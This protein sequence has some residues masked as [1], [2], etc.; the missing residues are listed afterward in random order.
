MEAMVVTEKTQRT[1]LETAFLG[2]FTSATG[3]AGDL[4]VNLLVGEMIDKEASYSQ[5]GDGVPPL[6]LGITLHEEWQ[7]ITQM[8][9]SD[10]H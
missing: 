1:P 10:F 7:A 3:I 9:K 5:L 8:A 2:A 4:V 6:D